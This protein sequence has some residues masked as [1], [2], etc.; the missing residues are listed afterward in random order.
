[1]E[2]QLPRLTRMWTHLDRVGG[3]GQVKGTGETQIEIDKRILKDKAAQ[4]RREL[5]SVRMHRK[6]YRWG[7][8]GQMMQAEQSVHT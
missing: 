7:R 2:Y 8:G 5:Q 3:G 6:A 1:V 4:L